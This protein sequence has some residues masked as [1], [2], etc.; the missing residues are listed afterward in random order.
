[1][2]PE[3]MNVFGRFDLLLTAI[4]DEAYQRA[5]QSYRNKVKGIAVAVS[6]TLAILGSL[7]LAANSDPTLQNWKWPDL[8]QATLIGLLATPLAPVSKDLASALSV[9]V[10]S[11]Q[12]VKGKS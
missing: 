8:L 4:L 7:V 5:D 11:M 10:K 6:V 1:M 2:T 3:Q 12:T 9:A